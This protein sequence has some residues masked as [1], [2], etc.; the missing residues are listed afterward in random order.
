MGDRREEN[1][2]AHGLLPWEGEPEGLDER[3]RDLGESVLRGTCFHAPP[4]APFCFLK[5]KVSTRALFI[6]LLL[7]VLGLR[8]CTGFSLV[9]VSGCYSLVL[10]RGL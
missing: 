9:A 2:P 4:V 6:Y 5:N 10:E 7:P 1:C 8:C 3:V